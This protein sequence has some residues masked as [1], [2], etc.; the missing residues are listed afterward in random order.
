MSSLLT[1]LRLLKSSRAATEAVTKP[2]YT[3]S[4]ADTKVDMALAPSE[5]PSDNV[6]DMPSNDSRVSSSEND[7]SSLVLSSLSPR[8]ERDEWLG[9]KYLNY[10]IAHILVRHTS[11]SGGST[12][13][14]VRQGL[15]SQRCFICLTESGEFY[16]GA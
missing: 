12:S 16:S 1:K 4:E 5:L 15:L 10:A 11:S 13:L 8:A 2:S 6:F 9:E 3:I 7:S 14:N